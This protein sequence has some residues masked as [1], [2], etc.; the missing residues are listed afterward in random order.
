M[1]FGKYENAISYAVFYRSRIITKDVL[2]K[3]MEIEVTFMHHRKVKE[4]ILIG[5]T[6]TKKYQLYGYRTKVEQRK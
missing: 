3:N 5:Y 4:I 6:L 1:V 2:R